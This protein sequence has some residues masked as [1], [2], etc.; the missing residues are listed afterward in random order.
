MY[1][2]KG[3]CLDR[4]RVEF[5]IAGWSKVEFYDVYNLELEQVMRSLTCGDQQI[6][7]M[8]IWLGMTGV[9]TEEIS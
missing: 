4:E 7:F 2:G 1:F 6:L 9:E 3:V 8:V 5:V